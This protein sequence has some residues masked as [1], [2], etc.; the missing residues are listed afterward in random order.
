M[1]SALPGPIP[2]NVCSSSEEAAF[3]SMRVSGVVPGGL[4]PD[5][6]L[7]DGA[8]P[9][10]GENANVLLVGDDECA[11]DAGGVSVCGEAASGLYGIEQSVLAR[12]KGVETGIDD[13]ACDVYNNPGIGSR[14]G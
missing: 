9:G 10:T 2:G 12:G 3:K 6:M 4:L 7:P 14:G 11:V 8:V 5:S 1:A 13:L